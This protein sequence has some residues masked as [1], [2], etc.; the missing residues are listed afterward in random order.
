VA[1]DDAPQ[2]VIRWARIRLVYEPLRL[3]EAR[4]V[5]DAR[6]L[7]WLPKVGAAW[8]P[9]GTQG[10]GITPGTNE[11][12][13]L[14][15]ALNLATGTVHHCLGARNTTARCRAL[16]QV[17]AASYPATPYRRIYGVVDHDKI[18]QAQAVAQGLAMPPR[19]ALL[20]LPTSCPRAHPLERLF[21]DVHALCTRHHTR[22]RLRDL[23]ADGVKHLH[24]NGPWKY[25]LSDIYHDPAV[26]DAV[27]KMVLEPTLATA[28]EAY[29]SRVDRFRQGG[30][31]DGIADCWPGSHRHGARS[32][33][34][35]PV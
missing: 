27:A 14:A 11:K 18:H 20:F 10:E 13:D 17:L 6:D 34:S 33:V 19:V 2:R 4:V 16:V 26:T 7:Q 30:L 21:G 12:H 31:C 28:S 29:Q 8:M 3:W 35:R 22:K 9:K 15:G 23:G 5:A 25:K 1:K 32:G 24:V